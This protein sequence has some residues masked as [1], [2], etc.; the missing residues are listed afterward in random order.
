VTQN[1]RYW[2]D[3]TGLRRRAEKRLLEQPVTLPEPLTEAESQRLI[4]ELH[5]HQIELEAQNEEL[6]QTCAQL[7]QSLEKYTG[8]YDFAPAG[9]FVLDRDGTILEANAMGPSWRPT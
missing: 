2:P 6:R 3:A 5:V 8:L 9:C 7:E 1:P 4:H